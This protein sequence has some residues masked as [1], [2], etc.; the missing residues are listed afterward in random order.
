MHMT[1]ENQE[2]PGCA[3]S[4]WLDL[5]G[6]ADRLRGEEAWQPVLKQKALLAVCSP[7]LPDSEPFNT[8]P[9]KGLGL[10]PPASV[11]PVRL[12]KDRLPHSGSGVCHWLVWLL[13]VPQTHH[14]HSSWK[15]PVMYRRGA[16]TKPRDSLLPGT[17]PYTA[18]LWF[19]EFTCSL[20]TSVLPISASLFV[21]YRP[22][23][24]STHGCAFGA[25]WLNE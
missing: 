5:S 1:L 2:I 18:P 7:R 19:P 4:F 11:P 10:E 17:A 20:A 6:E 22:P 9:G 16:S 24:V 8:E 21:K 23:W 25:L 3:C 13:G 12:R 15:W 14:M